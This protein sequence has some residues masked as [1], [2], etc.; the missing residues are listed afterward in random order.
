MTCVLY[1]HGFLLYE[2]TY[3]PLYIYLTAIHGVWPRKEQIHVSHAS[4]GVKRNLTREAGG[5]A[6]IRCES[7]SMVYW[8]TSHRNHGNACVIS[9]AR[10]STRCVARSKT[11]ADWL[12][13]RAR[14]ASTYFAWFVVIPGRLIMF[15]EGTS[16]RWVV[17]SARTWLVAV[18]SGSLY[19][20]KHPF[21][22]RWGWATGLRD[23]PRWCSD[24]LQLPRTISVKI[25][26][27][28]AVY[29]PPPIQAWPVLCMPATGDNR[30]I[31]D[32]INTTQHYQMCKNA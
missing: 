30:Q 20:I 28:P 19:Q 22:I 25:K 13:L 32:H 16:C 1:W 27:Y 26:T 17:R 6:S 12:M 11:R 29:R 24:H 15:E 21:Y 18:L 7:G 23:M 8:N 31:A 10:E 5:W 9:R 14:L 2:T 3:V 4:R